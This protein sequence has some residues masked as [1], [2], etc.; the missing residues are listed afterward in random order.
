[1]SSYDGNLG[2]FGGFD[3]SQERGVGEYDPLPT[4]GYLMILAS[5]EKKPTQRGSAYFKFEF[6]V[7]DG[8]YTGRKHFENLN[9]WNENQ[10]AVRIAKQTLASVC[11]AVNV[12]QPRDTSELHD[13]P[14]MVFVKVK[15]DKEGVPRNQITKIL[16][17]A[18][19]AK[20]APVSG[21]GPAAAKSADLKKSWQAQ[22]QAAP[23]AQTSREREPGEDDD[24]EDL[25][26]AQTSAAP[27]SKPAPSWLKR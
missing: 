13:I 1:M 9:L 24:L 23:V 5:S 25:K 12:L 21:R 2:D 16:S 10:E 27:I 6:E 8:E 17:Q 3:A 15:E 18:D 20:V 11:K 4:G 26:E 14:M 19:A 7:I 22:K